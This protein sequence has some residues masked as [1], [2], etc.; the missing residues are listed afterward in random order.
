MFVGVLESDRRLAD[1]FAGV[2]NGQRA[3]PPRDLGQVQAFDVFHHQQIR[4]VDGRH[5]A[6]DSRT[7]S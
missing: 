1:Q 4:V 6:P 5:H 7:A 3:E 2:R